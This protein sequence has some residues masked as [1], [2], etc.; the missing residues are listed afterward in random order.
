L[1][2]AVNQAKDAAATLKELGVVEE[3]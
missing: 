2:D 3:P 1:D